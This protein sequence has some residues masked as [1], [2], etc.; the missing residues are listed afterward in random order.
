MA[1]FAHEAIFTVS[2]ELTTKVVSHI[3]DS[4]YR[5]IHRVAWIIDSTLVFTAM[6][7]IKEKE[8]SLLS[9]PVVDGR[10]VYHLIRPCYVA[11]FS[12]LQSIL[13]QR[14]LALGQGFHWHVDFHPYNF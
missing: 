13:I 2:Y 1:G 11:V 5:T 3:K 14:L 4:Y 7:K 8:T 6:L 10:N 9:L 12:R